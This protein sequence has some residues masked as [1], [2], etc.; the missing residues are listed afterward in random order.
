MNIEMKDGRVLQG[1]PLQIVK[2]M[3]ELAFGVDGYSIGQYI[4]SVVDYAFRFESVTLKVT[5]TSDE[6]QAKSLVDEML[7]TD[8]ARRVEGGVSP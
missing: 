4:E 7:R 8:L 5:G 1:T 6:E 2:A 3:Q